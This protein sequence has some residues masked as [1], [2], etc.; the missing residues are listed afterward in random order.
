MQRWRFHEVA[1]ARGEGQHR[2]TDKPLHK[3][4]TPQN[5]RFAGFLNLAERSFRRGPVAGANAAD[6]S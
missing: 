5:F 3:A 4:K 6:M 2:A 1:N